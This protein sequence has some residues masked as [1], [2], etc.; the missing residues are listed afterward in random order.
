MM[1]L[2]V[3]QL[4][5]TLSL[6]LRSI[7]GIGD[8]NSSKLT[9]YLLKR[10]F[11]ARDLGRTLLLAYRK[12]KECI[13]C[14]GLTLTSKCDICSSKKRGSR[15]CIV[16]EEQDRDIIEKS[17]LHTGRYFVLRSPFRINEYVSHV[18]EKLLAQIKDM[19]ASHIIFALPI[20]PEWILTRQQ[21]MHK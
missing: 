11:L 4:Q 16:K 3:K 9:N 18:I 20:S 10:P 1:T 21:I 7:P 8:K 12:C 5:Q 2:D 15:L 6:H 17:G 19:C 13:G 14:R